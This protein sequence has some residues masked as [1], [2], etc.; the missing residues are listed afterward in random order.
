MTVAKLKII[1]TYRLK[2]FA[3]DLA[4]LLNQPQ[5]PHKQAAIESLGKI[6][7][8]AGEDNQSLLENG[9]SDLEAI[10]QLKPFV[11]SDEVLLR[12]PQAETVGPVDV[13]LGDFAIQLI[14]N[15]QEKPLVDFGMYVAGGKMLFST[16]KVFCF[17]SRDRARASTQQ[18]LTDFNE[19]Q[20][21]KPSQSK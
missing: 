3:D 9:A 2:A 8:P 15:L 4:E 18:W 14:L 13:T 11:L 20:K 17:K 21:R 16:E 1:H 19:S 5:Y 7:S 12:L 6:F 10:R